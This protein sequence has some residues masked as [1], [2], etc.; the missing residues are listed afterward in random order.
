MFKPDDASTWPVLQI[1]AIPSYRKPQRIARYAQRPYER[2]IQS[3]EFEELEWKVKLWGEYP[4]CGGSYLFETED[5]QRFPG[6][7]TEFSRQ[8]ADDYVTA[9][10]RDLTLVVAPIGEQS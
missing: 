7:V 4:Q 10:V 5:G 6:I 9:T 8:P 1:P 2:D 3:V